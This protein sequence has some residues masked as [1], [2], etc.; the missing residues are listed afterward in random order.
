PHVPAPHPHAP[1]AATTI[2]PSPLPRAPS[3]HLPIP[4]DGSAGSFPPPATA[5]SHRPPAPSGAGSPSTA[6]AAPPRTAPRPSSRAPPAGGATEPGSRLPAPGAVRRWVY[7][8]SSAYKD[9]KLAPG[10]QGPR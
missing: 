7:I 6:A 5:P 10:G 4:H 3:R 1:P 2:P 8:R 9:A